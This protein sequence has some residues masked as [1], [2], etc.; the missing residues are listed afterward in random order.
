MIVNKFL[1][2]RRG[3]LGWDSKHKDIFW[4]ES[5]GDSTF[6]GAAG[7]DGERP[8]CSGQTAWWL[9]HPPGT[10]PSSTGEGVTIKA[11][12]SGL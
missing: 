6:L 11:Q 12:D 10:T 9:Q 3:H 7:G 8:G 4:P 1:L 2:P 5:L